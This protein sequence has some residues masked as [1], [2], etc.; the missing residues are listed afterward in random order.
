MSERITSLLLPIG[1][2]LKDID[3]FGIGARNQPV[4]A[5]VTASDNPKVIQRKAKSLKD[6]DNAILF[7]PNEMRQYATSVEFISNEKLSA[8]ERSSGV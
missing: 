8:Y 4:H 3:I 1:H 7:A 5:Q 2:A 6:Y